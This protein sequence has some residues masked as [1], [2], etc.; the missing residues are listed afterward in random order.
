VGD[1]KDLVETLKNTASLLHEAEIPFL[2]GGGLACWARGG[3]ETEHDLDLMVKPEDADRLLQTLG[4]AGLRTEK[5]PEGWLYKAWDDEVMI[6]IIFAPKGGEI[7][8]EVFAR[9]EELEVS[10]VA[11]KVMALEDVMVTKLLALGEHEVD[12]EDVLEIARSLREQIDW[13]DVRARASESPY[14]R[15]FFFLAEELGV[16]DR[17]TGAGRA[18]S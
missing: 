11:M 1:F 15:A 8:D 4:D 2:L 7:D 6:D 13:D 12:Y 17:A 18:A 5:P 10:A 9:A 14:A 3:P 16:I